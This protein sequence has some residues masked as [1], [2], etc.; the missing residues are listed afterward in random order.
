MDKMPLPAQSAFMAV[1]KL[2]FQPQYGK[3][4]HYNTEHVNPIPLGEGAHLKA[5]LTAFLP[6]QFIPLHTPGVDL[7]LLVLRGR[8]WLI[9]GEKE[10]EL[11]PGSVALVPKGIRQGIR[12]ITKMVLF[13]VVA[14]PPRD[15]D[16]AE[17]QSNL[18]REV[19]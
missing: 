19:F 17:A 18:T 15:A 2:F 16:H 13:Q 12:A 3:L 10:I 6:G 1:G 4:V 5:L 8:G 11:A 14:P 7:A 9:A